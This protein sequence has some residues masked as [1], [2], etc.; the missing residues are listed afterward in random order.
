MLLTLETSSP[1]NLLTESRGGDE[2]VTRSPLNFKQDLT[3]I[4]LG[5]EAA[6]FLRCD[7]F[8]FQRSRFHNLP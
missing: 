6:L 1:E 5:G 3:K 8:V 2:R 4:I 7:S